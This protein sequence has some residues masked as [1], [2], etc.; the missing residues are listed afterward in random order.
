MM[1]TSNSSMSD[2]PYHPID[3]FEGMSDEDRLAMFTAHSQM[4]LVNDENFMELIQHDGICGNKISFIEF[5]DYLDGSRSYNFDQVFNHTI[6][7]L[8][9][10]RPDIN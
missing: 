8:K 1:T 2:E 3:P 4:I 10:M 6:S 7:Y 5:F 9:E